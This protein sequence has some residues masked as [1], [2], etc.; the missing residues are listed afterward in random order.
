MKQQQRFKRIPSECKMPDLSGLL[1]LLGTLIVQELLRAESGLSKKTLLYRRHFIR[2]LDK[3]LEEYGKAREAILDQIAERKRPPEE[4]AKVGLII[5]MFAFTDHIDTCINAVAR[6]YKL[7]DR[8]KSE[9]ESPIFPREIRRLVETRSKPITNIRNAVEHIDELIRNDEVA[10]GQ[11]IMLALSG[12]H[13]GVAVSSYEI[14]FEELAMVL[15]TMHEIA[16]Y[17]L[18]VKKQNS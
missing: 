7:L 10:P 15:R 16:Q 5:Y 1:P 11:P 12:N 4:M 13:D 18:T 17:I 14:K 2:I 3:A 8:I 6:L 9:P